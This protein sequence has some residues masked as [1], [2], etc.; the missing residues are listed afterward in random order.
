MEKITL[1]GSKKMKKLLLTL[2]VFATIAS[3]DNTTITSTM[4]LMEKG[5]NSIQ[6]GFLYNQKK[7]ILEGIAITIN[8]NNIFD[9]VDAKEFTNGNNKVQVIS[10]VHGNVAKNLAKLEKFVKNDKY[11]DATMQYGKVVNDCVACHTVIR[12]W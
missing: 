5:M 12:G 10:N 8:A 2:S 11:R 7:T 1:K 9:T 6:K 4:A 3:A